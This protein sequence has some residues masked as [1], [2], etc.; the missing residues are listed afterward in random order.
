[1]PSNVP[2]LTI[3]RLCGSGFQSI[4]SGAQEIALGD[5]RVALCAGS[6]NMSLAPFVTRGVRFGVRFGQDATLE[7]ALWAGLNDSYVKLPMAMTAENLAEQYKI[8]R[9]DV[10]A[11]ALQSQQRWQAAQD[12]GRFKE[13]ITPVKIKGR[14]GEESFE[15]DEHPRGG[16]ATAEELAKLAPIFKVKFCRISFRNR[17]LLSLNGTSKG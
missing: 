10:D 6:D 15:V 11:F 16:N 2:A 5:A 9:A 17:L 14:K 8:S 12:A 3:N 1:M 7:D 13:E 4:V